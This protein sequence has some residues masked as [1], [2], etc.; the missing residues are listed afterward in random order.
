MEK[1]TKQALKLAAGAGAVYLVYR[2]LYGKKEDLKEDTALDV[3]VSP[4]PETENA[5]EK[6]G[7]PKVGSG[8]DLNPDYCGALKRFSEK[9]DALGTG[10][11]YIDMYGFPTL[12]ATKPEY[13]RKL[14]AHNVQHALW[15]GLTEASKSFFGKKVLF[16]VEGDEW[17]E[18][19]NTMK[20]ALSKQNVAQM[21]ED[22]VN[23]AN[24]FSRSLHR[25]K[26][27]DMALLAGS[28]HLSAIGK[29]AFDFDLNCLGAAK[30]G[31]N[32]ISMS[33][34]FFISEL[35]RRSLAPDQ[36][37]L[38]NYEVDNEDNR[39]WKTAADTVRNSIEKVVSKRLRDHLN[40]VPVRR[41]LLDSMIEAYDEQLGRKAS[42][43][44]LMEGLTDNLVEILFAGYNTNVGT[45]SNA[46]YYLAKNPEY[47]RMAQKEIDS[48]IPDEVI[49]ESDLGSKI[50]FDVNKLTT[51]KNVYYETLRVAPPAPL[52]ARLLGK[53]VQLSPD[54]TLPKNLPVW[55]PCE[56]LQNKN[57]HWPVFDA[58]NFNPNRWKSKNPFTPGAYFPFSSGPRD[59]I[60]K[61]FALLEAIACLALLLKRFDFAVGDNYEL[62]PL[63]NGFGYRPCDGN[64]MKVGMRLVPTQRRDKE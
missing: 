52:V 9:I 8:M 56:Y 36:S 21:T 28:Y 54:L 63:F 15:A 22:V 14:L 13:V 60:G 47:M 19:R 34:E 23:I 43:E 6:L 30:L 7:I 42:E 33:F 27:V 64:T 35:P 45:I 51:L 57:E 11:G 61:N 26:E 55:F 38:G 20:S 2:F 40:G 49:D 41:D 39:K 46:L 3:K 62:R 1:T 44:E 17:R 31:P 58:S 48:L 59:C 16:V 32:E 37:V 50:R 5:M 25:G 24:A 53:D 18:L 4:E 12:I 29:S 10:I